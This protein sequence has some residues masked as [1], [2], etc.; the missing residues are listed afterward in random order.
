LTTG[1]E[2]KLVFPQAGLPPEQVAGLSFTH[3]VLQ[4][5]DG[6]GRVE[7]TRQAVQYCLAHPQWRIGLQTHK[8]LDLR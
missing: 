7:H 8:L 1:D 5:L 6:P 4:P 2:L 3:F